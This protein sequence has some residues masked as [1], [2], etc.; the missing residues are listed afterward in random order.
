MIPFR[1]KEKKAHNEPER[2]VIMSVKSKQYEGVVKKG[3][4]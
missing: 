3:L 2:G 4:V 1:K